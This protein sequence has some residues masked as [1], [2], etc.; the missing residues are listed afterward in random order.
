MKIGVISTVS[1]YSWAGSEELWYRTSLAALQRGHS[2]H[3]LVHQAV[4]GSEQIKLFGEAGGKV[5]LRKD[6]P[7]PRLT[8]LK[9]RFQSS[10]LPLIRSSD[11]VLIS[12][13]SILNLL[14]LP[15]LIDALTRS[16]T[17]YVILCQFNAESQHFSMSERALL[18]NFYERSNAQVFV[19][20]H[21]LVLAQRQFATRLKNAMV[22]PNPIKVV[23][24]HPLDFPKNKTV[25]L[26]CV[27]RMETTWKGHDV[28]LEILAGE[29]WKERDWRLNLYGEGPDLAY[30]KELIKFYSLDARVTLHGQVRDIASIWRNNHLHVL[31]SRG[32]GLPLAIL[33]SMM[34]GRPAATT[35]AG[36]NREIIV[37][38]ETGWVAD[39][40]TPASFGNSLE[41]AW[42]NQDHWEAMG[43]NAF[44]AAGKIASAQPTETLLQVLLQKK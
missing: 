28:L 41:Q 18:T 22:I 19:S 10:Y 2:V 14:F 17:P 12:A 39:A 15:G 40:A 1:G 24:E 9:E 32:E 21:N 8:S 3:A 30:V 5:S 36:G 26:A 4:G 23:L 20:Q 42:K 35:D 29:K 27:A 44:V 16:T 33:E 31:A 11:V 37:E 43:K 38:G 6:L 25:Q 13:G 34:C 7:H